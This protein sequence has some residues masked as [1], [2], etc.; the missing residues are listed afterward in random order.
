MET[1]EKVHQSVVARSD[2]LGATSQSLFVFFQ[3]KA[4][5]SE[6]ATPEEGSR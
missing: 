4:K 5:R 1:V 2:F 6:I 3:P